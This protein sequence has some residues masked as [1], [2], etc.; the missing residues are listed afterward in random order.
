MITAEGFFAVKSAFSFQD[1]IAQIHTANR[2]YFFKKKFIQTIFANCFGN[3]KL[4][5]GRHKIKKRS[6]KIAE[7][8]SKQT[9]KLFRFARI[10]ST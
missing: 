10:K 7:R 9:R 5:F 6:G 4:E 1:Q 3:L 8:L 2:R